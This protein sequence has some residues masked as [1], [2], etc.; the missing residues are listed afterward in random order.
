MFQV[1]KS[2]GSV[3]YPAGK[4]VVRVYGGA[5][6]EVNGIGVLDLLPGSQDFEWGYSGGT[7]H[8]PCKI[9]TKGEDADGNF[10]YTNFASSPEPITLEYNVPLASDVKISFTITK[11]VMLSYDETAKR[12][13]DMAICTENVNEK[14]NVMDA[15]AFGDDYYCSW[16]VRDIRLNHKSNQWKVCT[17]GSSGQGFELEASAP[18]INL[19]ASR[20]YSTLDPS[21]GTECDKEKYSVINFV[22]AD[23]TFSTAF[24]PNRPFRNIWELGA[25]HRGQEFRTL[26]LMGDD[27]PIVDQVKI[28]PF[29][30][31]RGTFNCNTRNAD[32]W[33]ELLKDIDPTKAYWDSNGEGNETVTN[34]GIKGI[35]TSRNRGDVAELFEAVS[36]YASLETDRAQE[37]IFG[38]TVGLLGTRNDKYTILVATQAL[39]ELPDVPVDTA[40]N[41]NAVSSSLVNPIVYVNKAGSNMA[42]S[43]LTTQKVLAHV[44]YDTWRKKMKI[45]QIYYLE[46]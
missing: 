3:H 19:D 41:F 5:K 8:E 43:V 24:I 16:Q 25:I 42:Y 40:D 23:N 39:K 35:P 37:A 1:N 36:G 46:E 14:L 31:V 15:T 34:A 45:L 27:K 20:N 32:A 44:F 33:N 29:K 9:T 26:S 28:G 30:Q 17:S 4:A 10:V 21:I 7:S 38:R 2:E 22:D 6:L 11:V 13:F 12:Y 18:N